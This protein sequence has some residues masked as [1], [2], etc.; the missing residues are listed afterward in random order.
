MKWFIKYIA[1]IDKQWAQHYVEL[2][3]WVNI[4]TGKSSTWKSALIDIFDYCFGSSGST[5]PKGVITEKADIYFM[6]MSINESYLILARKYN[7]SSAFIRE[8]HDLSYI[9]DITK[10]NH[11]YFSDENFI[12]LTDFKIEL[13]KHF[14][15]DTVDIDESIEARE[16]RGKKLGKPTARNFTSFILQ[17][18]NL[19]AN[20]HALFYRFEE[21][22]KR[23][24]TIDQFKIFMGFVNQE[25][26]ILKQNKELLQTELKTLLIDKE[27]QTLLISRITRDIWEELKKYYALTGTPLFV[28]KDAE[29]IANDFDYYIGLLSNKAI[30]T[31]YSSSSFISRR[32]EL[33]EQRNY[34]CANLRTTQ[35]QLMNINDSI[36]QIRTYKNIAVS[37][38]DHQSDKSESLFCKENLCPFCNSENVNPNQNTNKLFEAINWIDSELKKSSYIA[39][40]LK[41][42]K[43]SLEKDIKKIQDSIN[44]ISREIDSMDVSVRK[45]SDNESLENQWLSIVQ[46]IKR[47]LEE[48]KNT[49]SSFLDE[50]IEQIQEKIEMI[51]YRLKEEYNIEI[52]NKNAEKTINTYMNTLVRNFE[53]E[54]YYQ[55]AKLNFSLDTFELYFEK[56]DG[57]KIYLSSMGSGANWLYSHLCLF[58]ALQNYFCVR[59]NKCLIPPILFLDQPSQV[60]FPSDV[61]T[62]NW[63]TSDIHTVANIFDQLIVH[64]KNTKLDTGINPQII[65][66]DHAD[67][68]N[69]KDESIAFE[70]LVVA[71][72]RDRGFISI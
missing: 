16:R 34:F 10:L 52:N 70:S 48:I 11:N 40:D 41:N 61:D 36:E 59:G 57:D 65:I 24:Q 1:V 49:S 25:Y 56:L 18:Q 17:H 42:R 28:W 67:H 2:F 63:K 22:E 32:T 20:R 15:I 12:P 8:E 14:G 60:Y 72:W 54:E 38:S 68:L 23:E 51:D 43:N 37:I 33:E 30:I 4:I 45:L 64:C 31:N 7:S 46:W 5:I 13:S 69:L 53:F 47:L 55:N 3:E 39:L 6:V 66:M 27:K 50:E 9:T 21:K 29:Y 44:D 19:I 71:R 62:L 35:I 26:F 58:L